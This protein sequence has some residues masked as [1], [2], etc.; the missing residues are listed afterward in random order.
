MLCLAPWIDFI[1]DEV[2]KNDPKI[3]STT[4]KNYTYI[5]NDEEKTFD[6]EKMLVYKISNTAT[7]LASQVIAKHLKKF[8]INSGIPED[9]HNR[10]HMKSEFLFR[11]MLLTSTKK[12]YMSKVMLREGTVFEK[13]DEVKTSLISVMV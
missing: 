12:R 9:Y 3:M 13:L 11:R 2:I 1:I 7:Y 6:G 5:I 10:L 8:A 4:T